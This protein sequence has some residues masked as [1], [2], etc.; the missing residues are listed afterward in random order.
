MLPGSKAIPL[1]LLLVTLFFG[2]L[3]I[4]GAFL[5]GFYGVFLVPARDHLLRR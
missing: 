2:L 4:T 5:V 3:T 1:L